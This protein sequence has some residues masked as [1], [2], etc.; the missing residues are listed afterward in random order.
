MLDF[1]RA[2]RQRARQRHELDACG[3]GFVA[4][5]SGTASREIVD[6]AL[7]GLA[8]VRH[9][10]AIAADGISGD[11]AGLLT[12]IPRPFFARVGAEEL[13]RE[14]DADRLGVV[15]AFLQH[16]GL[17]LERTLAAADTLYAKYGVARVW[18]QD[19]FLL[20]SV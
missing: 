3:I 16:K 10:Q 9:R 20:S 7:T 12:P 8:C 15:S 17:S 19:G 1:D 13:G 4:H 6:L 5:A 11:G 18:R 14:L 2:A